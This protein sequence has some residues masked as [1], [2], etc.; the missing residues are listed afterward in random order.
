[1]IRFSLASLLLL[2]CACSSA[3]ASLDEGSLDPSDSTHSSAPSQP[4][5]LQ[6]FSFEDLDLSF[7]WMGEGDSSEGLVGIG[8]T[9]GSVD[10]LEALRD[11]YGPVTSLEI[12]KAFAPEGMTPHPLLVTSHEG[13][14]L[15]LGRTGA[16]LDVLDIDGRTLS[17][18]KSIPANCK[19]A[20]LPDISPG[21]YALFSQRDIGADGQLFFLCVGQFGQPSSGSVAT[22]TSNLGCALQDNNKELTVG[23]CNDSASVDPTEFFVQRSNPLNRTTQTRPSVPKNQI[24]RFTIRPSSPVFQGIIGLGVIGRNSTANTANFHRQVM[25]LGFYP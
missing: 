14:A 24:G 20:V 3:D 19:E 4:N 10:Y 23:I 15:A 11:G 5:V 18:D 1:M 17:I 12:F 16:A 8:E 21:T 9:F 7:E 22:T 13:E 25:G 6:R 2:A